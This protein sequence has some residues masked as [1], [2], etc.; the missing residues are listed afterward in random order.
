M[1]FVAIN[2]TWIWLQTLKQSRG[3]TLPHKM[4][5]A[6][7]FSAVYHIKS[8]HKL[9]CP[10]QQ[11]KHDLARYTPGNWCEPLSHTRTSWAWL[12][13][14]GFGVWEPRERSCWEDKKKSTERRS[15]RKSQTRSL[16]LASRRPSCCSFQYSNA[17]HWINTVIGKH[18]HMR[19]GETNMELRL[20]SQNKSAGL[21]MCCEK[22]RGTN[23]RKT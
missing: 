1:H 7:I 20:R 14:W 10:V 17:W 19:A 15:P 22:S 3:Q 4:A 21:M 12:K 11:H 13:A 9:H 5:V 8:T 23:E 16:V 18:C 2:F 6:H